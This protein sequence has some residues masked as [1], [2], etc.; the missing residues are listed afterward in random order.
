MGLLK[1]LRGA[2]APPKGQQNG[3]SAGDAGVLD[4][5]AF[6]REM[7]RW[8]ALVD[9][10]GGRFVLV[11][12]ETS[13]AATPTGNGRN[14]GHASKN[15][16]SAHAMLCNIVRARARLSDIVGI[17]DETG[18]RVAVILPETTSTGA[19]IFVQSVDELLR[20]KLNGSHRRDTPL[21]C[22]ISY[23]PDNANAAEGAS[24]GNTA[25]GSEAAVRGRDNALAC[26][27]PGR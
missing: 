20:A 10:S 11:V 18:D 7:Q 23:Y 25:R 13:P 12:F 1:L 22:E 14:N 21:L 3:H 6:Q 26:G 19:A 9:R 16:F 4:R 2:A 8:R 27:E 5:A 17:Y 15:G 24:E